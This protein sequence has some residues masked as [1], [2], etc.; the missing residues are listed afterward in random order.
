MDNFGANIDAG[1]RV[2]SK[3]EL[4]LQREKHG[5]C[6]TC[7]VKCF[8]KT[9]FKT[10]TLTIPGKVL[11]GRCL[12][13]HPQNPNEEEIL[14]ASCTVLDPSSDSMNAASSNNNNNKASQNAKPLSASASMRAQKNILAEKFSTRLNIG[15]KFSN[16][17]QQPASS[18]CCSEGANERR[19]SSLSDRS[20]SYLQKMTPRPSSLMEL[21]DAAKTVQQLENQKMDGSEHSSF[22]AEEDD[23]KIAATS[24]S[25]KDALQALNQQDISYA[26]IINIM[27]N[28]PQLS[29]MNEGLHALSLIHDPDSEILEETVKSHGFDVIIN[30]MEVCAKDGMAQVNACKVIFIA[31]LNGDNEQLAIAKAGATKSLHNAMKTFSEDTIVLEGCLLAMRNLCPA[32]ENISYMLDGDLIHEIFAT[33][34]VHVDNAGLQE[35]GC[36]I[37]GLLARSEEARKIIGSCG[38]FDTIVISTAVNPDDV[39][40]Q[41][42]ALNAVRAFCAID[43]ECKVL[44]TKSGAIDAVLEAMKNHPELHEVQEIG[45]AAL[46]VLG[47]DDANRIC[48]IVVR[49]MWSHSDDVAVQEKAIEALTVFSEHPSNIPVILEAGGIEAVLAAMQTHASISD[50]QIKGCAILSNFAFDDSTKVKIVDKDALDILVM[51]MVLHSDNEEIQKRS[52]ILLRKLCIKENVERMIAANVSPG[53]LPL[54]SHFSTSCA[55][56]TVASSLLCLSSQ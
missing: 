14:E 41:L 42:Q 53:K 56:L 32:E 20:D 33:M 19:C 15:W 29:V 52:V 8:E 43:D 28:N 5:K 51:A 2:L 46:S 47:I 45:C 39:E 34:N 30:A 12:H 31:C 27:M 48:E 6:V 49:S 54:S 21:E 26:D 1:G 55:T 40:V 13:C 24:I 37:L 9:F 17:E 35:H 50:I 44:L 11:N 25:E 23:T 18:S 4:I 36:A 22:C 7:G 3:E 10:L 38:G 16:K